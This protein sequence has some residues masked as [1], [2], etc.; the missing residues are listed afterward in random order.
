[1]ALSGSFYGS[2]VSGHYKL[3]VDWSAT[4]NITNNTSKITATM[5]LV[6]D[7]KLIIG[8]RSDNSTNIAGTAQAWTSPSINGTGTTK[9]GT[10]TSGNIAHNADGT[11][12]VTIS[13]TFNVRA[14]IDGT[15]YEKITASATITLDTIPRATTPTF[16]ASSVDLGSTL[17]IYTSRAS[18]SFKH[19]LAY[20]F[21]GSDWVTFATNVDTWYAWP[22]PD[23]VSSIPNATSGTMTIRCI[24]KNGGTIIGTKTALLTVKVPAGYV[25]TVDSIIVTEAVDGLANQ[26]GAFVQNKSRFNV[27][28]AA[29]GVEG[30]SITSYQVTLQ[31]KTYTTPTFTSDVITDFGGIIIEVTVVDS[32]GRPSLLTRHTVPVVEYSPP[33]IQGLSC[34]RC[35]A[36]GEPSDN[37][38]YAAV[39][40]KYSVSPVNNRNTALASCSTKR[41]TDPNTSYVSFF[42]RGDLSADTTVKPTGATFSTDNQ[43]T[44]SMVV[45]DWFGASAHAT[46]ILP[47]GAVILDI[48]ATGGGI[49][50]GKTAELPWAEFG[51]GVQLTGGVKYILLE[52]GADLDALLTPGF[53]KAMTL[54]AGGYINVPAGMAA[55]FCLEV[56]EA[57]NEGCVLQR[58][59][60]CDKTTSTVY[61]RWYTHESWAAWHRT[62]QFAGKLLASP[63][64]FMGNGVSVN[65][66]DTDL[67][68]MQPS[69]IVLV[70]GGYNPDTSAPTNADY[71]CHFIPKYMIGSST[72]SFN[73]FMTSNSG[74]YACNKLLYFRDN[75]IGGYH[76]NDAEPF[77]TESGLTLSNK[78]FIL[79][80]VIGV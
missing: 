70:F 49:A 45:T 66:P 18:T 5:Y 7:W 68:S 39:R 76:N 14:T 12:S 46:T 43:Y 28:I 59:T 11:K 47:S 13:A 29:S 32:R 20:S 35:D 26:F 36:N 8:G 2:I 57:N 31:G 63:G 19:D 30:S 80:H 60:S 10:V 15:Y 17:T 9:L 78:R 21:A 55:A 65:L 22:V 62:Q 27:S 34:Y 73:F 51:Y 64:N 1:M 72:R 61:E 38:I 40:L 6:N 4:Q 69:G 74:K 71:N 33:K 53:Y 77:A 48:L 37:G 42:T 79:S 25:P 56:T 75:I 67:I 24:T 23:L 54:E 3:R 58:L 41:T 44:V 50:F 16:H 52:N